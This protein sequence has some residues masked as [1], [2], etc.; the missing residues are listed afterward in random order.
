[1]GIEQ[2]G[3]SNIDL[4]HRLDT[5][6]ALMKKMLIDQNNDEEKLAWIE[7]YSDQVRE[8]MFRDDEF[9]LEICALSMAGEHEQAA[10]KLFAKIKEAQPGDLEQ[11]A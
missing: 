8:L 4:K 11:A 1:M 9:G 7:Y 10:S 2:P 6:V 5:E 3:Q